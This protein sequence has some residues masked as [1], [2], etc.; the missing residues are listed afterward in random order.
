MTPS[1][2]GLIEG[3][4]VKDPSGLIDM[5]AY[6]IPADKATPTGKAVTPGRKILDGINAMP[7]D[8]PKLKVMEA[9]A[10]K[11]TPAT[12]KA[13]RS[14]ATTAAPNND[15]WL[16]RAISNEEISILTEH[17]FA[18]GETLLDRITRYTKEAGD[19]E[20]WRNGADISSYMEDAIYRAWDEYEAHLIENVF[21]TGVLSD[22]A[23]AR[24]ADLPATVRWPLE[25]A[26]IGLRG[27]QKIYDAISSYYRQRILF[28]LPKIWHFPAVQYFGNQMLAL[29]SGD[30][31][32]MGRMLDPRGALRDFRLIRE[33]KPAKW[34]EANSIKT[35]TQVMHERMGTTPAMETRDI[36]RGR[37]FGIEGEL[38]TGQKTIRKLPGGTWLENLAGSRFARDWGAAMDM[39]YRETIEYT[40]TVR[41]M[42]QF[43]PDFRNAQ[44]NRMMDW[45]G[46]DQI[47]A[48]QLWREFED[49]L[50]TNWEF[51]YN[52]VVD[53][54]APILGNG[55]ARV[56]RGRAERMGRDWKQVLNQNQ[57]DVR[58]KIRHRAM[59]Q[60]Q[61]RA[62]L[63]AQRLLAFHYFQSRQ[64]WFMANQMASHPFMINL[65]FN[66]VE[67]LN[68]LAERNNW[69]PYMRGFVKIMT[70]PGGRSYFLNPFA[71]LSAYTFF[72]R[73]NTFRY[74]QEGEHRNQVEK[75]IY[76]WTGFDIDL[77]DIG[78]SPVIDKGMN[79]TG[80]AGDTWSPDLLHI[81]REAELFTLMI[82]TARAYGLIGDD[83][84]PIGNLNEDVNRNIRE[85]VSR[86]N[87]FADTVESRSSEQSMDR[88]IRAIMVDM[89]QAR[90]VDVETNEGRAM[91][92]LAEMDPDSELYQQALK[93]WIRGE[94]GEQVFRTVAGPL[95]PRTR[96][97]AS[98][99]SDL[100]TNLAGK[101][102]QAVNTPEPMVTLFRT[103]SDGYYELGDTR[104]RL[105]LGLWN[106][107]ANGDVRGDLTVNGITYTEAEIKAMNRDQRVAIANGLMAERNAMG[108]INTLRDDRSKFLAQPENK[109]FAQ[110]VQWRGEVYDWPGG[111]EEYWQALI[112]HNPTAK[113]YYD[114]FIADAVDDVARNRAMTSQN[115]FFW[116]HGWDTYVIDKPLAGYESPAEVWDPAGV[117]NTGA[118]PIPY[119]ESNAD[120]KN[121]VRRLPV[122]VHEMEEWDK[123]T[124][125]KKVKY[126][127]DADTPFSS[128][129]K[130]TRTKIENELKA[131]GHTEPSPSWQIE[132]YLEW[133]A[134]QPPETPPEQLTI[135]AFFAADQEQY[136]E[137][138]PGATDTKVRTPKPIP[139][140]DRYGNN[141]ASS[142]TDQFWSELFDLLNEHDHNRYNDPWV[143][144]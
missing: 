79:V 41:N 3:E 130:A 124:R 66:A 7:D 22:K 58:G 64:W 49:A 129:P 71:L 17:P 95:R 120:F 15:F 125:D 106:D 70:G 57:K 60:G 135:E 82:N 112:A 142:S 85:M 14:N 136:Y 25:K 34:L 139:G 39:M 11:A 68:D 115:A 30:L 121:E 29:V 65:Y 36:L 141:P 80:L 110:F 59:A 90:G 4:T 101:A 105:L 42:R 12:H 92:A 97:E 33:G 67:E 40:E 47:E 21:P 35:R 75:W 8:S 134:K 72:N 89:L 53:H 138:L 73:E 74:D 133:V 2:P 84:R 131:E 113:A 96:L 43:Y 69:P 103:Q 61:T 20:Q 76:D 119:E 143:R 118:R 98:D 55:N 45:L 114:T 51:G 87:P 140:P 132:R 78:I 116:I 26:A 1:K 122:F 23:K 83:P 77:Q 46:I 54:F 117:V 52:D 56:G 100:M 48:R 109:D 6:E 128:L 13:G 104:S 63:V 144:P 62:D 102:K 123:L 37:G 50:G 32:V 9:R 24:V 44:V 94:W 5:P 93:Q 126:G 127:Y 18:D 81:G 137:S 16:N 10:G 88:E 99:G 86:A 91:L 111:P 28:N 108:R 19:A 107:I 27:I 31:R 38:L